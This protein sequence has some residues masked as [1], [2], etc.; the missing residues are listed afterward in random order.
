MVNSAAAVAM[1]MMP[2]R[3]DMRLPLDNQPAYK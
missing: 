3:M 1:R 2:M